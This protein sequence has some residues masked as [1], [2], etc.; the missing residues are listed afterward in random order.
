MRRRILLAL[1]MLAPVMVSAV[2]LEGAV[3]PALA[4]DQNRDREM[5]QLRDRL[6]DCSGEACVP[7]RD[8]LITRMQERLRDCSGDDCERLRAR[9]RDQRQLRSC[10]AAG[11]ACAELRARARE[12]ERQRERERD[13]GKSGS[14]N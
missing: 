1:A 8:Q 2:V 13:G 9:L 11:D 6:R 14:R 12:R 4:Q 3:A 5:E 10:D 7:L